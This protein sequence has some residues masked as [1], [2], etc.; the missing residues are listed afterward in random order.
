MDRRILKTKK[1]LKDTLRALLAEVPFEKITVTEICNEA[2]TGRLTFYKYY[3]DKM[4]LLQDCFRDMQLETQKR[5]EIL[6]K[7]NEKRD[8][9]Q[10]FLNLTEAIMDMASK[11]SYAIS[12]LLLNSNTL[13]M[14]YQFVMN[15]L[16]KFELHG[17]QNFTT[18]YNR[19][20]LNSFLTMGLWGFVYA[21]G[22]VFDKKET[23]E[24]THM[25]IHD[26]L[27]SKIF[28]PAAKK[29][30]SPTIRKD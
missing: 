11:N 10:S 19:K 13:L 20:Q 8:F 29:P 16:E 6:Q 15:N 18:K 7:D 2:N 5:Y 14:Y 21:N 26:L 1:C 4:D 12:K 30:D 27:D 3:T 17:P 22:P 28:Q 23:R 25:L 24:K 9:H